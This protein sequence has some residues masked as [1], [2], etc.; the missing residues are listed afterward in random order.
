MHHTIPFP[1]A[2]SHCVH[3]ML[4]FSLGTAFGSFVSGLVTSK[5]GRYRPIIWVA[6]VTTTLGLGLM[7][8][9]DYTSSLHVFPIYEP[10]SS[11]LCDLQRQTRGFPSHRSPWIRLSVPST[12]IGSPS[13]DAHKGHG[14]RLKRS[15]VPSVSTL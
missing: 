3:R 7:I 5:T 13:G 6:Y 2:D 12:S 11:G 9:L 15:H 1:S 8:M 10:L 14:Y 4:T